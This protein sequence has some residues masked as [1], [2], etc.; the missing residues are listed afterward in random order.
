[1]V[2]TDNVE[3]STHLHGTDCL[4]CPFAAVVYQERYNWIFVDEIYL[5]NKERAVGREK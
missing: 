5:K 3:G 1:M 4:V 2:D